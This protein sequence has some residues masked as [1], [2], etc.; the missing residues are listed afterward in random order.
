MLQRSASAGWSV[1]SGLAWGFAIWVTCYEPL[2]LLG[3]SV[4]T[5]FGSAA[6]RKSDRI[7]NDKTPD[8]LT[9][10]HSSFVKI[11]RTKWIVF[12]AVLFCALLIER[13]LPSISIFVRDPIFRNW[14]DTIEELRTVS[15]FSPIWFAWLGGLILIVPF[16]YLFSKQA[17]SDIPLTIWILLAATFLLTMW[18]VRWAYF[19]AAV[20]VIFLPV[21]LQSLRW[22]AL[23]WVGFACS[24]WPVLRDWDERLWPNELLAAR[25]FEQ[26]HE[27]VELRELSLGLI[28][29][30]PRPVLAPWWL[31]PAI[32]YWSGQPAV[33]G[34]SH[35]SLSGIADTALFFLFA[36][37]T[38]GREILE[39]R[40]V[41]WVVSYD[42]ERVEIN[43]SAILGKPV[44]NQ[45]LA[46]VLDQRPTYAPA[47]LK[48]FT[49]NG[50]GKIF[51]VTKK[52]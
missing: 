44:P 4:I 20:F 49:Q 52:W 18:Q 15:I 5:G 17:R 39:R 31:S 51:E 3:L 38:I 1:L 11:R 33:A 32:V 24:L 35:E 14:A 21:A 48:L 12:G 41:A 36:N 30:E 19:L 47:Y 46:W 26:R 6:L 27:M 9:T 42:A 2:L 43:A 7:E 34:S 50:T 23:A 28:S 40:K 13:R 37:P 10:V 25:Q 45:S 22:R 8:H 29:I 16:F